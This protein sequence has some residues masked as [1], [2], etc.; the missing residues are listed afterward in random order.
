LGDDDGWIF[1]EGEHYDYEKGASIP[2]E[3]K[4]TTCLTITFEG[5][6]DFTGI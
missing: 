6:A 1:D 2:I 4:C 5:A 3:I